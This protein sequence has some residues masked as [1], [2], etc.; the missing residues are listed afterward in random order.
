M[1]DGMFINNKIYVK[2]LLKTSG[3]QVMDKST[4]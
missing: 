2:K 4:Y 3:E 1:R